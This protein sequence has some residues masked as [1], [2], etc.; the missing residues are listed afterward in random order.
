MMRP[1]RTTTPVLLIGSQTDVGGLRVVISKLGFTSIR[2]IFDGR[3][4][5]DILRLGG[6][7][8]V[9]ADLRS[10]PISGLD[11]LRE[12][13]ADFN[14]RETPFIMTAVELSFDEAIAVKRAGADSLVLR[15]CDP[16]ALASKIENV[17]ARTGHIRGPVASVPTKSFSAAVG[18][19]NSRRFG[20]D[21][22]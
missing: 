14:L 3:K 7:M 2:C 20:L 10:K 12:L 8:L 22:E 13:R 17:L 16:A 18:R 5:A 9:I 6:R 21:T 15:P 19:R 11:L 1:D 4:T